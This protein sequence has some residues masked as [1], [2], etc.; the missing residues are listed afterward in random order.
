MKKLGLEAKLNIYILSAFIGVSIIALGIIG[1]NTMNNSRQNARAFAELKGKEEASKIKNHFD[2]AMQSSQ[3]VVE[4]IKAQMQDGKPSRSL[5]AQMLKN[6]VGANKHYFASW[7]LWEPNAFDGK[8]DEYAQKYQQEIGYFSAS[9]YRDGEQLLPQDF[10]SGEIPTFLSSDYLDELEAYYYTV[11]KNTMQ[12]YVDDPAEY[13]YTGDDKDMVHLVSVVAPVISEGKFLGAVGTDFDFATLMELNNATK[14]YESGF[15]MIVTHNN[16]IAAHPNHDYLAASL[17]TM[18]SGYT[19]ALGDCIRKGESYYYETVSEITN[20]EAIRIFSPVIIGSTN[21]PWSV[22]IE[23]PISEVMAD[24]KRTAWIIFIIGVIGVC[25]VF[26]I[27]H[28]I[29]RKITRPIIHVVDTMRDIA[30]GNLETKIVKSG[31]HDEIGTLEQSLKSMLFK[32]REVVHSIIE[33]AEKIN[34]A[35][36]QFSNM[37]EQISHGANEQAASVEEISSTTEEIAANIE[38]NTD[39]AQQTELI[40]LKAQSGI[41]GVSARSN[42]TINATRLISEKIDIINEIAIQT[43][44]LALNAA[45]EAARAGEHGKGFAVVAAEVRKLAENSRVAADEIMN[46]SRSTLNMA[47][48]AGHKMN[49]MLPQIEKTTHLLQEIAAASREQKSATGQVN[50]AIQELNNITQENSSSSEE[51]A[52]SAEELASQSRNLNELV[53]YF[54][55]SNTAK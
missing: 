33:G 49:E 5:V 39:N 44:I 51:L 46:H 7:T 38:Q 50:A 11:P 41:Q 17:D 14:I 1:N 13:S 35:S 4:A 48:E 6:V 3:T 54:K 53:A 42:E 55:I 37:A 30:E 45:V 23:I 25:I 52:A 31:R 22:M 10:S 21:A 47:E 12:Q 2:Y 40:S 18:I 28:L 43:N 27:T 32:L 8:D 9:Y 19:N 24:A 34:T 36:Q 15:S 20:K 16:M 26:I 29:S